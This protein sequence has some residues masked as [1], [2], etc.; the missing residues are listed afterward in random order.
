MTEA[1]R[2]RCC[3]TAE[4]RPA[5]GQDVLNTGVTGGGGGGG[6]SGGVE[7]GE[8]GDAASIGTV[9]RG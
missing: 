9:G 4:S 3:M 1:E 8:H 5:V 7:D 6:G 2:W